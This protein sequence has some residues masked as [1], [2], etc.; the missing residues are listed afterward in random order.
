MA[1]IV[2]SWLTQEEFT[3]DMMNKVMESL[4]E[5]KLL[6]RSLGSCDRQFCEMMYQQ[7]PEK[8][9]L[10]F[11]H[12]L[13]DKHLERIARDFV[14]DDHCLRQPGIHAARILKLRNESRQRHQ[15]EQVWNEDMSPIIKPTSQQAR[16]R[17]YQRLQQLLREGTYFSED[18]IRQRHP[19]IYHNIVGKFAGELSPVECSTSSCGGAAGDN[20]AMLGDMLCDAYQALKQTNQIQDPESKNNS[21]SMSTISLDCMVI[22]GEVQSVATSMTSTRGEAL[23]TTC[24]NQD[25]HLVVPKSTAKD[26]G[27]VEE[28]QE[29]IQAAVD[30]FLQGYDDE[31]VNYREMIDGNEGLDD[32]KDLNELTQDAYFDY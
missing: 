17:R 31:W 20:G 26:A 19:L 32:T 5:D 30:M 3:N 28:R 2:S 18:E 21:Y 1:S 13:D 25:S 10:T 12:K 16:N 9:V 11:A 27:L 6:K 15:H 7:E 29:L 14:D 4:T 24:N 8:F 23:L 22:N